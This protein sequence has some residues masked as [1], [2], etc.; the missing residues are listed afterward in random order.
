MKCLWVAS[1]AV[2]APQLDF[3]AQRAVQ[4]STSAA[5]PGENQQQIVSSVVSALQPSI[6]ADVA[7]AIK[8]DIELVE[9]P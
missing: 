3:G 4:Y 8:V 2:A 5:A 1:L 6:A 9:S 7:I